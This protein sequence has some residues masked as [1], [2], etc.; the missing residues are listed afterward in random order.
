MDNNRTS[1]STLA[2]QVY[3]RA[4]LGVLGLCL[5]FFVPAGT[6]AYWQA[7]VFMAILLL[8]MF[9]VFR[10]LLKHNPQLLERRMQFREKEVAQQQIIKL[11]YVYFFVTFLL[12]GFDRRWGW[13]NVPPL[14]VVLADL[15][16]I[17]GY[18]LF[19]M[20]LAENQYAART[21]QVETEQKVISSGPY[22]YVRHP[23]YLGVML[24]Y[25]AAPLAL[26]SY[27]ALLP[28]LLIIPL[29]VARINNEEE[30]L[31]RELKGYREYQQ[32]TRHR[33]LPNVW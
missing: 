1:Q 18:G 28:A 22:A 17:L 21:I 15:V 26:G 30:V 20:V 19:F 14:V 9:V 5:I 7:W 25:L 31:L 8:P 32:T 23:M 6:L 4:S 10:Y 16:V 33:L 12:P 29:L 24:I 3:G 27:W 13:S 2:R 11:S